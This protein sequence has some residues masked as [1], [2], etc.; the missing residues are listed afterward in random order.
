V[1]DPA[2]LLL[3]G[4]IFFLG[5]FVK[6]VI[7]LGLPTVVMGMLSIT[8]AP[9][10][11]AAM[12]VIP[13]IATNIWQMLA[14]PHFLALLRRMA[15]QMLGVAIGIFATIGLLT[16]ASLW[17]TAALGT[18]LALY[19]ALGF[20]PRRFSVKPA[21]EPWLS[22]AIGLVN[23]AVAGTTGVFVV[24]GVPYLDALRMDRD[25]L[26]QAI[27]IHAFFCPLVLAVALLT[28]GQLPAASA[29]TG[30]SALLPSLAG[31]Y[32]GQLLRKRLHPDV[33]RRWFFAGLVCLGGYMV[34]RSLR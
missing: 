18:V 30:A 15:T 22:P 2:F 13:A 10:Q 19:G 8:M 4:G 12:L 3:V 20:F 33:F 34:V 17:A 9:A 23:G 31:M 29:L 5:G 27:G 6:G 11:A 32:I 25:M 28:H 16:G 14:G 1:S 21:V 24:P 26:I 7:G